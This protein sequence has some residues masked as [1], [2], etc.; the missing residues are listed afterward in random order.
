MAVETSQL[1]FRKEVALKLLRAAE[2]AK[3]QALQQEARLVAAL[4][5]PNIVD[6]LAVEEI[7]GVWTVVMEYVDGGTLEELIDRVAA[8]GLQIPPGVVL[9]LVLDIARGLGRAH[10]ATGDDG[11]SVCVLHRDLKPANVLLDRHGAAR[12]TDFGVAKV[13]GDAAATETGISKGTPAY[14]APETWAGDREFAPPMDLFALGCIGFELVTLQRL[15][16][17]EAIANI[18][19]EMVNRPPADEAAAVAATMPPLAP[20]VERLL[21]RDPAARYQTAPEVEADLEALHGA[22]D[23]GADFASFLELLGEVER[24]ER[25]RPQGSP[26]PRVAASDGVAWTD[27]L[28]RTGEIAQ[29]RA[30]PGATPLPPPEPAA[31]PKRRRRKGGAGPTGKPKTSRQ[32]TGR[33]AAPEPPPERSGVPRSLI[34]GVLGATG[35]MVLAIVGLLLSRNYLPSEPPTPAS[36][37]AAVSVPAVADLQPDAPPDSTPAAAPPSERARTA[38][39]PPPAAPDHRATPTLSPAS[40]PPAPA[41]VDPPPEASTPAPAEPTPVPGAAADPT[42]ALAATPATASTE[43][44]TKACLVTTSTPGRSTVWIDGRSQ[45]RRALSAGSTLGARVEPGWK[46]IGMG[47]GERPTAFLDVELV[48]GKSATVHCDLGTNA[49]TL[50]TGGFGPCSQ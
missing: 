16:G 21:A 25:E 11:E 1:G 36:V 4:R 41:P 3:V 9:S 50:L 13:V 18:F 7:E 17:G 35:L 29:S 37:T 34:L 10:T 32:R 22:I 26:P 33:R 43:T 38:P 15:F 28:A 44:P 19:W 30:E 12:L 27:L 20:V 24:G 39:S 6:V 5:H 2:P 14:T 8:A 49:C 45:S 31:A 40:E 46:T 48:L 23:P 42:P 47:T